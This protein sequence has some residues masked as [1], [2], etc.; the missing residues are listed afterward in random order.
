M[1][2]AMMSVQ[3]LSTA[4][5]SGS[6]KPACGLTVRMAAAIGDDGFPAAAAATENSRSPVARLPDWPSPIE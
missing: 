2:V 5:S 1:L 6:R 4:Q 3:R